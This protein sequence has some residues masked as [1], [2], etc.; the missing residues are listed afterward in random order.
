MCLRVKCYFGG[1]GSDVGDGAGAGVF[2][3]LWG[4]PL[5]TE[6]TITL[7]GSINQTGYVQWQCRMLL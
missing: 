5:N 6:C 4:T 7:G 1:R 2:V 3:T